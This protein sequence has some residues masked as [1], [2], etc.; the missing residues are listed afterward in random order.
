MAQN[1][2]LS[3]IPMFACEIT[4][5]GVIGG[6]RDARGETVELLSSR[7]FPTGAVVPSLT[8]DNVVQRETV[9]EAVLAVLETIGARDRDITVILPDAACHVT[10]LDF[11]SL[12]P[13]ADDAQ[14]IV[15]FR[16]KKSLPFD[17][18]KATVSYHAVR[19]RWAL[20][21]G[22]EGGA[23][24][25]LKVLA[26]V[27]LNTVLR[28]YETLLE[29]FGSNPGVVLPSTMAALGVVEAQEPTLALKVDA[30]SSSVAIVESNDLLLYRTLEH[31]GKETLTAERLAEDIYPSVVYVQDHSQLRV[32]RLLV[33]G[34]P[35]FSVLAPE[36][37]KQTGLPVQEML[38][39]G[40][41]ETAANKL[42]ACAVAGALLG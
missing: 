10:L 12:P 9:R 19:D 28:E 42:E 5:N 34:L 11:D 3:A 20:Q 33:A 25:G 14:R 23:G 8:D 26:A 17:V 18:E 36:L 29:E 1:R 32:Q 41:A 35:D 13:R 21:G 38:P 2:K 6:R 22:S 7:M 39:A 4:P 16:L 40:L 37:E 15:R 24:G 30:L 27:V 31:A